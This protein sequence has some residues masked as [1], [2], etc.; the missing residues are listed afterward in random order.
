MIT[1]QKD[2]GLGTD[3]NTGRKPIIIGAAIW[4]GVSTVLFLLTFFYRYLDDLARARTGT[5]AER[6]I[7]QATGVYAAAL[8]FLLVAKF[9]RRYRL[10]AENWPRRI[11]VYLLAAIAFSAMH[12]SILAVSRKLIFPLAGMGEYDYGIMPIRYLMEFANY[13]MWFGVWVALVHLFDHYQ[14]SRERELR[15]AHLETQLAQA[16]I[17]A[18]QAQ[19][20]PH[21]LFN[22]LNTISSVIYEDVHAADTM[23]A[24]LSDFLR[25]S[26]NASSAQEVTLQEELNFLNLYLDVMRPRFEE[27][28]NVAFDVEPGLDN[29]L[30]PKLILQ[31]LV[32][33]SVKHAADPD[34]GAIRIAVRARRENGHLSLQIEDD[35][36]GLSTA[37]QSITKNG[38]GL[39]NTAERL[40]R[41]YGQNQEFTIAAADRGGVLVSLK[42]PYHTTTIANDQPW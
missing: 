14:S 36:P 20:H 4:L 8:L 10:N 9:A 1:P 33:N 37:A 3:R 24:R 2:N 30:T 35:G 26:L 32:E 7:E 11:P 6:L 15:T 38:I 39:S 25:H 5:F 40:K 22:A 16:Q 17:Q 21:F 42:L 13:A 41:L 23:I 27:R 28:L 19:I 12:T 18:L 34:S 31:P 29:A